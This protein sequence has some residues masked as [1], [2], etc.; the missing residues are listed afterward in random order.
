M[1]RFQKCIVA[2]FCVT[3]LGAAVAEAGPFARMRARRHARIASR[4]EHRRGAT[5][6]RYRWHSGR[7]AMI[8]ARQDRVETRRYGAVRTSSGVTYYVPAEQ[9]S[10]VPV[11]ASSV[12]YE[13]V[14]VSE[15]TYT[16]TY[17][18]SV[19]GGSQG[20]YGAG[21]AG[22]Y[23]AASSAGSSGAYQTPV[24][25]PE[26][27]VYRYTPVQQYRQVPPAVY[28]SSGRCYRGPNGQIICQ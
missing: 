9:V 8:D 27:P 19:S 15:P 26:T 1:T 28:R 16:V 3:I 21:S 6:V 13:T 14:Y 18:E 2:L 4:I 10:Y 25:I 5:G 7:A 22:S 11:E 20:S 24:A 12:A 17:S 23:G